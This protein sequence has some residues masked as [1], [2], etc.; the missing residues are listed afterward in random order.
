MRIGVVGCGLVGAALARELQLRGAQV[1]VY[2]ADGPGRGTSA[3]TFA[4][5]NSFDK[6]PRAYHDLNAAGIRAHA[7]LQA[8][9]APG[10]PWFFQTGNLVWPYDDADVARLESCGY[11]TRR[12]TPSE[13]RVLEPDVRIDDDTDELLLLPEEGYVLPAILLARLLGEAIDL[14]AEVRCPAPVEGFELTAAGALVRVSGASP[15]VVDTVVC[16]AGRWSGALLGRSGHA[17]PLVDCETRGS[18]AVGLLA[19]T[20][21]SPV[22]LA[23]VLTTPHLN[24]RPDGAGRLVLQAL[25][26]DRDV[27]PGDVVDPS[28]PVG[29]EFA[30]RL[31]ALLRGGEHTVL[32]AVR[33]GRRVLPVDGLSVVGHLDDAGR[34]YVVA[35]H[36]GVTLAPLL[37]RLA[38]AEICGSGRDPRLEPFRPQRLRGSDPTPGSP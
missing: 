18:A 17:L 15:E 29:A 27:E 4:W 7:E 3:T 13:A 32:D 5:V 26:L 34:A 35:T 6:E 31:A 20:Q 16:C 10:P 21:P 2:E 22:R 25:E 14:G 9:P 23:R 33:L 8:L 37:A 12:L 36:S 30:R 38:A 24:V 28:G 11:A 19:F 1:V